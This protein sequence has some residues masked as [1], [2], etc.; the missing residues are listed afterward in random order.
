MD[1]SKEV[2]MPEERSIHNPVTGEQYTAMTRGVDTGGAYVE[3]RGL[4]PPGTRPP[5]IHRHPHQD[6]QVTVVR[7]RIRA[8]IGREE[9]EYGPGES[10]ML[11]RGVWHDF[12]VISD[13]PAV[14]IG[15]ATPALGIEMLLVTLA[16]LAQ[17]GRTDR[18]GRP[19]LLQ[20]AVIGTFY[21]EIAV[22]KTPPP[23]V[24]RVLLPPLAALGRRR[25]YRPYYERHFEPGE[26]DAILDIWA[27]HR[28]WASNRRPE[29]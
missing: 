2:V 22:F 20:G 21:A 13:E 26:I 1:V 18:R 17:E 12:W 10:A 14:T 27:A 3:G 11:P 16:G 4:L 24:Q 9:R 23:A 15:R 25:G 29:A 7:G 5:G 6:E 19:H 28:P 8:R